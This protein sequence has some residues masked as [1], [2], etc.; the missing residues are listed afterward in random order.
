MSPG[1]FSALARREIYLNPGQLGCGHAHEVFGTLLG[2][3]VAITLW[4]PQRRLGSICHFVLPHTPAGCHDS[5]HD[6]RYGTAAFALMLADH[7]H[8]GVR[9]A[10]CTAKIF[11]GGSMFAAVSAVQDIGARNVAMA[12]RLVE[13]AGLRVA[14]ENVGGEGYRRLYFDVSTGE[15]WIKFDWLDDEHQDTVL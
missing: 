6:G 8:N 3:C 4:H 10:E 15:V 11:G 14:A 2:S 13:R 5:H 7:E 12:R 9:A 1:G